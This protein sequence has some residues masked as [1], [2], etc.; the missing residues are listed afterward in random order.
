MSE[1]AMDDQ[2]YWFRAYGLVFASVI[3]IPEMLPAPPEATVE[4][5]DVVITL[6]TFPDE[7]PDP[8]ATSTIH[9]VNADALLLRVADIGRY[10][11]TGGN[12]IHIDPH[13]DATDHEVRVYLLG[14]C[15]GALLHQRD[16]LVLH[17]SGIATGHGALL[18]AG[19]S[20]AGKSTLL[21]EFLRRGYPMLVDDVCAVRVDADGTPIV[22]PSYPRTRLW[23]D[24][25]ERFDIDT[26][27][28]PRTVR[29]WDKFE[30]QV[31]EFSDQETPLT[32]LIHLLGPY[33]GR[34]CVVERL[35]PLEAFPTLLHNTYRGI[36]LDGLDRRATH[37]ALAA[38][39]ARA[40]TVLQ[41]KRPAE[42]NSVAELADLILG[43][44]DD[45]GS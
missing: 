22:I 24:A 42:S 5:A 19:D 28:L 9:Q 43:T 11:V 1:A 15:L 45:I 27:H 23:A 39:T 20:G 37:F 30:R 12:T 14:T 16:F 25:A 6:D 32:H 8:I 34:E 10:L 18:F 2:H 7:L 33:P 36:L 21:A 44:L 17:A 41:A 26:T 35:A 4:A 29:T 38:K 40:I 13:P 3:P 31:T